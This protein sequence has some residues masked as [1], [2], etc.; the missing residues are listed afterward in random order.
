MCHGCTSGY[1]F[2]WN[3]KTTLML[4]QTIDSHKPN[5][6]RNRWVAVSIP[7]TWW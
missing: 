5:L 3:Q 1:A 4:F 7:M 2:P 6:F